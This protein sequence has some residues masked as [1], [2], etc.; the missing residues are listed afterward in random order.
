MAL[1]RMANQ[2]RRTARAGGIAWA[3]AVLLT[4]CLGDLATRDALLAQLAAADA[5]SSLS[6]GDAAVTADGDA[7]ADTDAHGDGDAALADGSDAATDGSDAV[8]PD[9]TDGDVPVLD[10]PQTCPAAPGCPCTSGS[11]CASGVCETLI[12]FTSTA[13]SKA[14]A[15]PCLKGQA[16]NDNSMVCAAVDVSPTQQNWVFVSAWE[17]L[18]D[19]CQTS[20]ACKYTGQPDAACLNFGPAGNFCGTPCSSQDECM[21]GF[22][23]KLMT[24][25]EGKQ[26]LTGQCV[27]T[28]LNGATGIG[29]C[30]CSNI[31]LHKKLSTS[32]YQPSVDKTGA[33]VGKCLG[34]RACDEDVL[35]A[36]SAPLPMDE[37]CDTL[38]N[39][40]D[41]LVDEGTCDDGKPCT[42]D[43]CA[44]AADCTHTTL[45][46]NACDD[47]SAC[48]A[49]DVCVQDACVGVGKICVGSA[50]VAVLCDPADGACESTFKSDAAPCDDGNACTIG[51]ACL[52]GNCSG[53]SV[54]CD[55]GNPCTNDS[56]TPQGGCVHDS[57]ASLCND[58]NACTQ[59]D[60]CAGGT[61][62]GK[63]LAGGCDDGN[64]CTDD[65]CDA[66]AGCVH[67]PNTGTCTDGNACTLTDS[68]QNG[69]CTP[70][71]NECACS[72]DADCKAKEDGNLCNGTLYCD[73]SAVP[74]QCQV[75]AASIITCAPSNNPCVVTACAPV[76]GSCLQT[77][78]ANGVSCD[79][80]GSVCTVGDACVSGM[81]TAGPM[82]VCDDGN[83]CTDD[84]CDSQIGCT[85]PP[86]SALC[87]DGN[88][89]TLGDQ[90]QGGAC[91]S[92]LA[93]SCVPIVCRSNVC[94]ATTGQCIATPAAGACDDGNLCTTGDSCQNG[95]CQSGATTQCVS[96]TKCATGSC[97][98]ATGNCTFAQVACD[99]GNPCTND[100]CAAATG[101]VFA[102]KSCDDNNACTAD[103]CDTKSGACVSVPITCDDGNAC[104]ADSCN[105]KTGCVATNVGD[106][107]TCTSSSSPK[108]CVTG[109]CMTP[110]AAPPPGLSGISGGTAHTCVRTWG[111]GEDC[112][113]ADQQGQLGDG[114][115]T[116]RPYPV[117]VSNMASVL[118]TDCGSAFTCAIRGTTNTTRCWGA[119]GSGQLGNNSTNPSNAPVDVVSSSTSPATPTR[120][121]AGDAFACELLTNKRVWCWGDN[122]SQQL[123]GGVLGF[124]VNNSKVPTQVVSLTK[125]SAIAAGSAH[126][127]AVQNGNV[128]C[129][130]QN[131]DGQCGQTNTNDIATPVQVGTLA[132]ITAVAAGD[133]FSCALASGT[134]SIWC[135]GANGRGQLATGVSDAGGPTPVLIGVANVT[136]ITAGF[137]HA[138]ART[139]TGG[140]SCWGRND[141]GQLGNGTQADALSPVPVSGMTS[142][143]RIGAGDDHTC[144]IRLNGS[145]WCWGNNVG[146]ALGLNNGSDKPVLA[147]A[148]VFGTS[149]K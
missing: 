6:D 90:C 2:H 78:V 87:S 81:C 127:C 94:D 144:A 42:T 16:F 65:A 141:A 17:T 55:D 111:G 103:S 104:T 101:C 89:C 115:N 73:T 70:G 98:L 135:W 32:C 76:T 34:T 139:A 58:N 67:L 84:L 51:D 39:D 46:G 97:D 71:I 38:D 45:D 93:V 109:V 83:I 85:K 142:A 68:C 26:L 54:V 9:G 12:D 130:G 136:D 15:I 21:S 74:F 44:A 49:N 60:Q 30:T 92:G 5:D 35:T 118:D 57:N 8:D 36:C 106:G 4:G 149:P 148:Q 112:W 122:G 24:S 69:Q 19:P 126:A 62:T 28:P 116:S 114:G 18:C 88:A 25:I 10:A 63:V 3:S 100:S 132:N 33:L 147:P 37:V 145:V 64:V 77:A 117:A 61:C 96:A 105:T 86:N 14:C 120:V 72:Q 119:N 31:A 52:A 29:E 7:A 50:C 79:A 95:N 123:G 121:A 137:N 27:P 143:Y 146:G 107:T 140:M 82:T 108:I 11:K 53:G 131:Q 138:C 129:W 133:D 113:G 1:W 75:K 22:D 20:E 47:G 66:A 43:F 13:I 99:D 56:C 125:V 110:F 41:G 134:G 128:F 102:A 40:C 124:A 59:F 48:T 23:C 80:D 91:I